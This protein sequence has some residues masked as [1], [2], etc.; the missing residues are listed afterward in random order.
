MCTMLI[1]DGSTLSISMSC[2]TKPNAFEKF[3]Q[4]KNKCRG[5]QL[6]SLRLV[7]FE[8]RKDY[9]SQGSDLPN[10]TDYKI[11]SIRLLWKSQL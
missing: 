5:W 4:L 2:D 3:D 11:S 8:G 6:A 9:H 10:D 7:G 1:L